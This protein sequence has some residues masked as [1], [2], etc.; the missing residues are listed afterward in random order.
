MSQP[1]PWAWGRSWQLLRL[2]YPDSQCLQVGSGHHSPNPASPSCLAHP[3]ASFTAVSSPSPCYCPNS[4]ACPP[5]FHSHLPPFPLRV[6]HPGLNASTS[7]SLRTHALTKPVYSSSLLLPHQIWD[8]F[9][10]IQVIHPIF[11]H[12][13]V[14]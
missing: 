8:N 10:P 6:L 5:P 2:K 7:L 14:V 4:G 11:L 9:P 13:P 12:S 1:L 3:Q